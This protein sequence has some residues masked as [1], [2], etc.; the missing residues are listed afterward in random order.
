MRNEGRSRWLI[1]F[2]KGE[3][4]T[5][6]ENETSREFIERTTKEFL[7]NGG[8]IEYLDSCPIHPN[9]GM[10]MELRQHSILSKVLT[11]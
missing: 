4:G 1:P 3:Q 10:L 9:Y 2:A 11:K 8:K 6:T 5:L 7:D